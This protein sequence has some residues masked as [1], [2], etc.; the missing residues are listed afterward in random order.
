MPS[1]DRSARERFEAQQTR[2]AIVVPPGRLQCLSRLTVAYLNTISALLPWSRQLAFPVTLCL[3]IRHEQARSLRKFPTMDGINS[4]LAPLKPTIRAIT[5]SLPGPLDKFALS[6]LGPKCHTSL[7]QRIDVSS[8][9]QECLQLA[10]SKALGTA[11]ITA[12]SIVKVPQLLKLLSSQSAAGLSLSSYVLETASFGITLAYS[13]RNG[14]PFS[15]FGETAFIAVQDIAI[16]VL[17]LIFTG[18]S[19]GAA[20]FVAVAAAAGYALFTPG[21]I[22]MDSMK[23]LQAGASVLGIAS[24]VPQIWTVY[25][26]GGTGQLSA[27]AV[28][29]PIR[30]CR[31]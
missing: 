4:A 25:Q 18:R 27:F 11:I 23:Y 31:D 3:V 30:S 2:Q 26:E 21:T 29:S 12:A 15:T 13:F 24:K 5:T 14:F 8:A 7:L 17:I 28:R 16:T 6:L 9:N 1:T 22:D 19:A 20:A 10:V